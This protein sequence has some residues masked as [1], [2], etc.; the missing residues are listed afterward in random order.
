MTPEKRS[1]VTR[2]SW[3]QIAA[4]NGYIY[5]ARLDDGVIK[6]GFALSPEKRVREFKGKVI[7]TAKATRQQEHDLHRRLGE[8]RIPAYGGQIL[9][10]E[11]YVPAVL[12]YGDVPEA[13]KRGLLEHPPTPK[14]RA[15]GGRKGLPLV[16]QLKVVELHAGGAR[17]LADVGRQMGITRERVRQILKK[18]GVADRLGNAVDKETLQGRLDRYSAALARGL[19]TKEALNVEGLTRTELFYAAKMLGAARPKLVRHARRRWQQ[20]ADFYVA[21]PHLTGLDVAKHFG[22][23]PSLV[24]NALDKL[25]VNSRQ[26]GWKHKRETAP[27]AS[28]A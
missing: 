20:I 8:F 7:A 21:N 26:D 4:G 5:A 24:S 2:A 12:T 25:G 18:H 16:D 28:P 27:Q 9:A 13:L 17:T 11:F 1:E 15:V 19:T 10:N 22:V 3:A 23:A 6:I 14:K